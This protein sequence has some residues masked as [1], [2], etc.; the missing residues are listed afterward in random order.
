MELASKGIRVN[1]VC[2]DLVVTGLK[3]TSAHLKPI[4]EMTPMKRSGKPS[5]IA[6]LVLFLESDASSLSRAR[7]L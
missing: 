2:P 6:E 7:T 4:I 5:E 1:S 3:S